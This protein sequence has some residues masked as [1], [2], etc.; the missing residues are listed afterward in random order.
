M[1]DAFIIERI[2]R[3]REREKDR[4]ENG[5]V[6]LR[7]EAPPVPSDA[8]IARDEAP[9]ERGSVVIDFSI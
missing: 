1:L 4:R 5:F 8:P 3:E 6:P 7:I 9:Q 2:R